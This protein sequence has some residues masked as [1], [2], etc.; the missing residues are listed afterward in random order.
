MIF[1]CLGTG[2]PLSSLFVPGCPSHNWHSLFPVAV[3]DEPSRDGIG[4]YNNSFYFFPVLDDFVMGQFI[5]R[6]CSC[7]T[8]AIFN[9][10]FFYN[11]LRI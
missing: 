11:I 10:Q 2:M 3:F 1:L 4:R 7:R 9:I 8:V 6:Q 5:I